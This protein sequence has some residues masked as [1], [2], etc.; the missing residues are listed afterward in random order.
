MLILIEKN[1]RLLTAEFKD[2]LFVTGQHFLYS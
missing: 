2:I 1:D